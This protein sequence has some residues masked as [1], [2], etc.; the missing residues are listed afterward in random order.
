M[1][2]LLAFVIA[3]LAIV[4]CDSS[5]PAMN[6]GGADITAASQDTVRIANDSLEYEIIIIEPN[7]NSWLLT[8]PPRGYYSQTFLEN[9]NFL[10]VSVYNQR[11][12]NPAQYD[13]NL[14]PQ[15]IDYRSNVDYG[16][17]VNYMLYNYFLYFM[18]RYNQSF[19]GSRG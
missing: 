17:E 19:P 10:F 6:G 7:F 14:Y 8:Q 18:E 1:K 5:R 4:S 15:E 11:V 12:Y 9:R 13:P 16:Y 2:Y 3:S